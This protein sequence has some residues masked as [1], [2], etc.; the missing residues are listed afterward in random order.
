MT[1]GV[2]SPVPLPHWS[3][4][5]FKVQKGVTI[6]ADA[7]LLNEVAAGIGHSWRPACPPVGSAALCS[8]GCWFFSR[9]Q[10]HRML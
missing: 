5:F 6:Q 4:C 10:N 3:S 1:Q 2:G 9:S 7:S 8:S